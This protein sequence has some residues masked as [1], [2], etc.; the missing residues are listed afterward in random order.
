MLDTAESAIAEVPSSMLM[1]QSNHASLFYSAVCV[2]RDTLTQS[3]C[4]YTVSE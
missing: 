2:D 1:F 3:S 4:V